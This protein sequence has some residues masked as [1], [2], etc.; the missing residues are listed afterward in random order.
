MDESQVS[1]PRV[2]PQRKKPADSDQRNGSPT[3]SRSKTVQEEPDK[4]PPSPEPSDEVTFEIRDSVETVELSEALQVTGMT[5]FPHSFGTI[6]RSV[7]L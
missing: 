3:K 7:T 5:V 1:L 2:S 4:P 6:E